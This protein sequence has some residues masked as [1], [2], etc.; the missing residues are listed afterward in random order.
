MDNK[1]KD[2]YI[3][4]LG[5]GLEYMP[6]VL[7]DIKD[8]PNA[9]FINCYYPF[10]IDRRINKYIRHHF[11]D[12][13]GKIPGKWIWYPYLDK[14]L[15]VPKDYP[16]ILVILDWNVLGQDKRFLKYIRKKHPN[17]R[18][19][20]L[21]TNVVRISGA[22]KAGIV[23]DLSTMYDIV[24]TYDMDDVEHYHFKYTPFFYSLYPV[25]DSVNNGT[26]FFIGHSK[27]R[28]DFLHKINE[29]LK[30]IGIQSNFYITYVPDEKMICPDIHYNQIISYREVLKN[31]SE[32]MCLLDIIQSNSSGYTLKVREAVIYNKLLITNN[33]HLKEAPFYN[34]RY[35]LVIEKPE[36][37]T[38]GFFKRAKEV[39]YPK[40]AKDLFS[41]SSFINDMKQALNIY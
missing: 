19:V 6:Y 11:Q 29:R 1:T 12:K 22:G 10:R 38:A 26:V 14:Q 3:L 27:D 20:Y 40:E 34:D 37:I 28:L 13:N 7:Y 18:L 35:I 2:P 33:K 30:T 36:D 31:V 24:Y 41:V 8:I 16:A 9:E 39:N 17:L 15:R 32:S 23:E 21:F 4:I 25:E 5:D